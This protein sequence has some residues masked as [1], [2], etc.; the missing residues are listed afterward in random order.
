MPRTILKKAILTIGTKTYD[1][2]VDGMYNPWLDKYF[3][4]KVFKLKTEGLKYIVTGRFSDGA[5]YYGVEW[6]IN[7]QGSIRTILTNDE[8]ILFEYME[9]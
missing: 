9:H 7:G 1:L 8:K 3:N 4:D 2:Q 5:G 6:I